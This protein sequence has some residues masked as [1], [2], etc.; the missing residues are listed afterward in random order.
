MKRGDR[1]E[2]I[3]MG[4][5]PDP[6][7]AKTRGTVRR[8]GEPIGHGPDAVTQVSVN[9]DTGRSLMLIVPPDQAR[10]LTA[11]EIEEENR[12]Q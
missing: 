9:W 5:D 3:S 12:G 1:I 11:E 7:P 8:V 2:L 6:I 4:P 10:V